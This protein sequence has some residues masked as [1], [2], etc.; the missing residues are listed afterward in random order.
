MR[1]RMPSPFG[2]PTL[3]EVAAAPP[4]DQLICL[5]MIKHLTELGKGH[6]R[7]A[8]EDQFPS[9]ATVC[10]TMTS[11]STTR[12][13]P[14]AIPA[15][16]TPFDGTGRLDL[17]SHSQNIATLAAMGVHGFL[18]AGSTGEGPYLL[19]GE[20]SEL[21][22]AARDEAADAFLMCGIAAQSVAQ[23]AQQLAEMDNA[24][25][26]LVVTPTMFAK[27]VEDQV[28]FFGEVANLALLPIWLYTVP[29]VTGYNLPTAAVEEL[30]SHPN[31]VGIKDSSGIVERITTMRHACSPDFLIYAGASRAVAA[32]RREGANGAI[33]ASGNY[34]WD[35]VNTIVTGDLGD[36]D[37]AGAQAR[38]TSLAATVEQYGVR[39]T[40][41][42][43]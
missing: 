29:G 19:D 41:V 38:L 7:S 18:I 13:A 12:P 43:A 35:L 14:A 5:L 9:A 34:A 22:G 42:A 17:S 28:R 30:A 40:K 3:A 27:T 10:A 36:P 20:R 25:V 4:A 32:A 33:T 31:V 11:R 1:R 37:T 24:D 23:A 26:A 15:L 39:G 2:S 8:Q 6:I 16:I 21:L